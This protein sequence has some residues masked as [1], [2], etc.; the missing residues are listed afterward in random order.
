[1]KQIRR[2]AV[3]V[4]IIAALCTS[5]GIERF[6]YLP[7]VPEGY[8]STEF[9]T[10]AEITIPVLDDVQYDFASGYV[11]FYRIYLSSFEGFTSS[12]AGNYNEISQ[13]LWSH[14]VALEPYT[15]PTKTNTIE[16]STFR[17]RGYYEL[18]IEG[19]N[20]MD[21]VLTKKGGSFSIIF[22]TDRTHPVIIANGTDYRLFR[23]TGGQA[24]SPVPNRYFLNTIEIR[25]NNNVR[26]ELNADVERFTGATR[27]YVS[28]YIAATGRNQNFTRIYGKPTFINVFKLID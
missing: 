25:D 4:L 14:Y 8:I 18:E 11:I 3:L 19:S 24:F 28:M 21:T 7:Q 27:A 13:A 16:T 9:D 26:P 10:L 15:D 23:S 20:I 22:E 5:C 6:Y 1:M 2:A 12:T 17:S